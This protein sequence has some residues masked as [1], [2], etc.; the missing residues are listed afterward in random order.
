MKRQ[1]ARDLDYRDIPVII[2]NR[3]RLSMLQQLIDWLERAEMRSIF[4]IDN[5]ST[6]PPLLAYYGGSRHPVLRLRENVGYLALWE[7]AVW[8]E[9]SDDYYVYSDSDVLPDEA[10]P[11]DLVKRLLELLEELPEIEKVGPGLRID[12]LT[13]ENPLKHKIQAAEARFWR[14]LLRPGVYDAQIDT[15]F[16]LYRPY[17][18]GGYWARAARTAAPYVARHLPWY[19]DPSSRDPEEEFYR[20]HTQASTHWTARS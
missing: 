3:N 9:F 1:G 20:E 8:Q 6:Y 7:T 11:Y 4:I 17:A 5:A 13:K 19:I 10:C 12:D 15:T 14:K 2:N 18:R 16:A